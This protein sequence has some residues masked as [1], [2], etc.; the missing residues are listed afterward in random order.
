MRRNGISYSKIS[1]AL[2]VPKGTLSGW[3]SNQPWSDK[4]TNRLVKK[5]N[6]K[7]LQRMRAMNLSRNIKLQN[8]YKTSEEEAVKE[9]GALK[10]N[11]LFLTGIS[12]YWG[13]GDKVFKNGQIRVSNIDWKMLRVFKRFLEKICKIPTDK[14]KGNILF[15]PD[16]DPVKCLNFW[17][18]RVNLPKS[19][20]FKS[21]LIKGRLGKGRSTEYGVCIIQTNNK[22]IKKKVLTWINLTSDFLRD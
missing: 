3:L 15:Y 20:F 22:A 16:L 7:T 2:G 9:F 10:N 13:E 4:I 1:K 6:L 18:S 11:P 14:I 8:L 17:S 5:N 19:S 21:V 12:I